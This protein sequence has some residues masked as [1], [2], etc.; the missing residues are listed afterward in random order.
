MPVPDDYNPNDTR[1]ESKNLRAEDFK[2]DQKW[3]LKIEDVNMELMLGRDGKP[4]RNRLVLSFAGKAKSLVLNATNQGFIEARLGK[5]PNQWIDASI[6][7]H[8]TT[9]SLGGETVPAFRIIE[10]RKGV[11]VAR[12]KLTE[13]SMEDEDD[14]I[15]F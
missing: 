13:T 14:S 10:V 6:M 9:T 7:L 1:P 8:R 15:P 2:L 4:D 5:M 11:V 3:S 12:P